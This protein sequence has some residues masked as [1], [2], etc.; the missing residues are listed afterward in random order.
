M[1]LRS[2][3]GERA[4]RAKGL[5]GSLGQDVRHG[6]R[7]LAKSPGTTALS[8]SLLAFGM[9]ANTAIFSLLKDTLLERLPVQR[10]DELVQV[11]IAAAPARISNLPYPES[12]RWLGESRS[13]N[14]VVA[15]Y[16]TD[17]NLRV[18]DA[19][20]RVRGRLVSG[21]YFSVLGVGAIVGRALQPED[22]RPAAAPAAVLSYEFWARRFGRDVNVLGKSVSVAGRAFTIVG[23]TPPGF[24]GLN[25]LWV[26][27]ISIPLAAG[28]AHSQAQFLARLK[29]GVS[30]EQAQAEVQ[31]R[32]RHLA[33]AGGLRDAN[34]SLRRGPLEANAVLQRAATG[35]WD[36]ELELLSPLRVLSV[37]AGLTLLIACL[38]VSHLLLAR[39]RARSREYGVRL[40]L[41]AG[42]G[43][44]TRQLLV[45]S[46]M[47]S[48]AGC[49][50]GVS[51]ALVVHRWLIALLPLEPGA[52]LGFQLDVWMLCFTAALSLVC[53]VLFGVA[54][55]L[56]ATRL[57]PCDVLRGGAL[58]GTTGSRTGWI[59]LALGLQVAGALV[60]LIGALAFARTLRDLTSLDP[61]FDR[62]HS[63][64]VTVDPDECHFGPEQMRNVLDELT[65]RAR[66]LP[67]VRAAAIGMQPVSNMTG[68][69]KT[70]WA[71]GYQYAPTEAQEVS[72][73]VVGPGFFAATGIPL[74]KGR[75]F[76]PSD[77]EGA[78]PVALVNEAFAR[79]YFPNR[80]AIGR[81]LGDGARPAAGRLVYEIV[82]VVG[83]ARQGNLRRR[84]GPM[85]F[86]PLTQHT[87]SR[88]FV[89]HVRSSGSPA[90]LAS[91]LREVV[92]LSGRLLVVTSFQTAAEELAERLRQ[93]R[94]FAWLSSLF[95]ALALG[96]ACVGL[97]G[98]A[99]DSLSRRTREM[100]IR[101]A[102]GATRPA[103]AGLVIKETL[104]PVV[105][106]TMI[107]LPAAWFCSRFV[108]GLLLGV[109]PTGG[110]TYA[111]AV[112]AL[113]LAATAAT[114]VPVR[115]AS[116]VN[117]IEALRRE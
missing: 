99:S 111:M 46:V 30:M 87:E 23:I 108:R 45:E 78:P 92:R 24:F 38:N 69:S 82:G 56:S 29:P 13:L 98:M 5:L 85:V 55:V 79:K 11:T 9:G 49:L 52:A 109:A 33:E 27:E 32:L 84:P 36:I 58:A 28:P 86:H 57:D 66:S 115:R 65:L 48:A 1:D 64:L 44:L 95:G 34:W 67:G 41:G 37:L 50:S 51:V 3:S 112:V 12:Q 2:P 114:V 18:A 88:P 81:P 75:D 101:V 35:T 93:E 21:S 20:E 102:I 106:G 68:W 15:Y 77:Q 110:A 39:G 70:V 94:M 43:R 89:L 63:L 59:R 71:E 7:V 17:L 54:P 74:R 80:D 62:E 25:R 96:L 22:D 14:G 107:G 104:W 76:G 31:A 91:S 19:A 100:G 16:D 60:L 83:D 73:T 117:P 42:R 72:F 53:G 4:G 116:R 113:L 103:I 40:A 97:Y 105:A 47:L 8:V 90:A 10:P 6:V 61:G 26:P